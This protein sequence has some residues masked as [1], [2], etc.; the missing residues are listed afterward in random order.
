MKMVVH[1]LDRSTAFREARRVVRPSGRFVITTTDPDGFESFWLRPYFPSYVAIERSRFPDGKT[2]RRDL[3]ESEFSDVSV[4]PYV[5][6]A[7]LPDEV[8]YDLLLLS[9]VATRSSTA[10]AGPVFQECPLSEA[11]PATGRPPG[12]VASTGHRLGR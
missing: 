4:R 7:A 8:D 9:V 12:W 3:E 5:A 6:E 1:H 10:S 2:V 11:A